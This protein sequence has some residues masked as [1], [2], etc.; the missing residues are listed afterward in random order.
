[1]RIDEL[2]FQNLPQETSILNRLNAL[3]ENYA[4]FFYMKGRKELKYWFYGTYMNTNKVESDTGT[5]FKLIGYLIGQSSLKEPQIYRGVEYGKN[6]RIDKKQ[7][8]KMAQKVNQGADAYVVTSNKSYQS[9]TISKEK[10][11]EFLK[12]IRGY[13]PDHSKGYK[14]Y[15]IYATA[16]SNVRVL[17]TINDLARLKKPLMRSDWYHYYM[18]STKNLIELIDDY[19]KYDQ[20]EVVIHTPNRKIPVSKMYVLP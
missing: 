4:K 10:A 19:I 5:M 17:F 18:E 15:V 7:L 20:Q 8:E 16:T 6:K 14:N 11:H 13:S 3:P 12:E 9:W 1:M 2:K